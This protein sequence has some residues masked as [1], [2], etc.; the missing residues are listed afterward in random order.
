MMVG[1]DIVLLEPGFDDP[2]MGH[3]VVAEVGVGSLI[4]VALFVCDVLADHLQGGVVEAQ[5][6]MAMPPVVIARESLGW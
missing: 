5:R 2:G 6:L 1:E 4:E 3:P